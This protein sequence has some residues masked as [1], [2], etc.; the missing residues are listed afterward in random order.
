MSL[1]NIDLFISYALIDNQPLSEEI[2]LG[3][4]AGCTYDMKHIRDAIE[5]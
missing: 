4:I 3:F 1:Y 2:P 5:S